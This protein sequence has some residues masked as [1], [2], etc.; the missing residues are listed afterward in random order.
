[1]VLGKTGV[2]IPRLV[3]GLGSR[4]MAA[5]E[6]KGLEILETG[7]N[8][9]LYHWDTAAAYGS[10]QE[11]SETRVGKILK[12][13]RERVFLSSKVSERTAD[14]AE[15]TLETSL[16]RLQ[17]DYIDLYQIHSVSN[18]EEVKKF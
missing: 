8:H 7:L 11:W 1:V 16:K 14:D 3:M 6:E 17:T 2:R 10:E 4:F 5:G 12:D 9:G 15:R 18:E 13:V